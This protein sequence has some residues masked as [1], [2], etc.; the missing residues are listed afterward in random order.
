MSGTEHFIFEEE[1]FMSGT[2]HIMFEKK[3]FIFVPQNGGL[4]A[5]FR[6]EVKIT[7]K[8]SGQKATVEA[9]QTMPLSG[10]PKV[11]PEGCGKLAADGIPG[12]SSGRNH[13]P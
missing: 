5:K 12:T 10:K 2:K 4:K 8:L 11:S 1:H 13:A 7:L 3:Q 6:K 9:G